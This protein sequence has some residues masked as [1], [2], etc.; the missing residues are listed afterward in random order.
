MNESDGATPPAS[1]EAM[2]AVCDARMRACF[3][4]AQ[5]AG[6]VGVTAAGVALLLLLIS[7]GVAWVGALLVAWAAVAVHLHRWRSGI[8]AGRVS[9]RVRD[10]PESLWDA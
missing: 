7:G 3:A 10:L 4:Q 9:R 6:A 2:Q 5:I 8:V 1:R